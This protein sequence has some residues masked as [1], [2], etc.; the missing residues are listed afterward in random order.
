MSIFQRPITS[1]PSHSPKFFSI[2][3][4]CHYVEYKLYTILKKSRKSSKRKWSFWSQYFWEV[5][6]IKFQH[7]REVTSINNINLDK[8]VN[9]TAVRKLLFT[10]EFYF[11]LWWPDYIFTWTKYKATVNNYLIRNS[12]LFSQSFLCIW[13]R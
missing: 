4:S 11:Y 9:I 13:S 10:L 12:N 5:I 7:L 6:K 2:G 1:G 3:N 8:L